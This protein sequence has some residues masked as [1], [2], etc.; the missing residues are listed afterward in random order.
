MAT[1]L[2]DD[3]DLKAFFEEN[4]L[5]T[6]EIEI[7]IGGQ[8]YSLLINEI[9]AEKRMSLKFLSNKSSLLEKLTLE[10][11][12]VLA[13]RVDSGIYHLPIIITDKRMEEDEIICLANLD[14]FVLHIE[15]RGFERIEINKEV[16]Y[17]FSAQE[18]VGLLENLSATGAKLISEKKI[19]ANKIELDLS[20][21]GLSFNKLS[22]EVVWRNQKDDGYFY[23][24]KFDFENIS[25]YRELQDWL[26]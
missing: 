13:F 25:D 3:L 10:K 22:A 16:N 5:S 7:K 12:L 8:S 18:R 11:K 21:I 23:G 6:K 19:S 2:I 9:L 26:Y 20:F 17:F 14:N 4:G 24:L 15:R 1:K